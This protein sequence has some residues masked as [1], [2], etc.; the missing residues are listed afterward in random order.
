M[1]DFCVSFGFNLFLCL[2]M[3][4]TILSTFPQ[5]VSALQSCYSHIC[6]PFL[7]VPAFFLIRVLIILQLSIVCVS[8]HDWLS[9]VL[10]SGLFCCYISFVLLC[11]FIYLFNTLYLLNLF[12]SFFCLSTFLHLTLQKCNRQ[13]RMYWSVF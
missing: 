7:L 8:C 2:P 11:F 5:L 1:Y 10:S 6:S 13:M 3:F 9:S 4:S 12:L